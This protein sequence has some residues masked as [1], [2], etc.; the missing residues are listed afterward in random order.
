MNKFA[1]VILG[2]VISLVI[3]SIAVQLILVPVQY[4]TGRSPESLMGYSFLIIYPISIFLGSL[5]TGAI[6]KNDRID[7]LK[8]Q[9]FISPGFYLSVPYTI[10]ILSNSILS[11]ALIVAIILNI[12]LSYLGILAGIKIRKT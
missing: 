7:S 9:I 10:G 6:I 11:L 2:A 4:E 8:D 3:S 1:A 5:L 12:S